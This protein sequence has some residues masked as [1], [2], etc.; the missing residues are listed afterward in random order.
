MP[1]VTWPPN[2]PGNGSRVLRDGF[3]RRAPNNV[4]SSQ[5]DQS[6]RRRRIS[7]VRKRED[8]FTIRMTY[9][10]FDSFED[11]V[12]TTLKDGSLPF[13]WQPPRRA[14]HCL[15]NF[16]EN[17]GRVYTAQPI[18]GQ[19]INVTVTIEFFDRPFNG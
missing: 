9:D 11:W 13:R 3:E 15:S 10:E 1:I 2:I 17:D 12:Q 18:Q 5:T 16:L 19:N 8:Q 4:R 6:T 14:Y 7:T